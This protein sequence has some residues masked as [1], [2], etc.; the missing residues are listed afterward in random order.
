M[1]QDLINWVLAGLM[2]VFGWLGKTLWDAVD[3][4]KKDIKKI[5]VDLPSFYVQKDELKE[6]FDK[7]E[8]MLERIYDKLDTKVDK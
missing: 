5:E 3:S 1:D 4:L 2:S 8:S 6:K 7:L